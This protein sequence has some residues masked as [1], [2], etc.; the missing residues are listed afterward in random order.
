MQGAVAVDARVL[1]AALP[2]DTTAGTT[3]VYTPTVSV[4]TPTT[5]VCVPTCPRAPTALSFSLS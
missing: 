4:A 5:S 1:V 2:H 3:P